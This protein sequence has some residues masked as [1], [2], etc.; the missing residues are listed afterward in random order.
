MSRAQGILF[1]RLGPT[2]AFNTSLKVI[3][4]PNRRVDF[5]KRQQAVTSDITLKYFVAEEFF[6]VL[7]RGLRR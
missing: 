1:T 4:A 5:C 7:I 6:W 3:T 2:R